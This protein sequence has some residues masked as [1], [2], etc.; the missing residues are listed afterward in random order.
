MKYIITESQLDLIAQRYALDTLKDMEFKKFKNKDFEFFPKGSH[1]ADLGI[2][3]DWVKKE[4][5]YD[6][7]VGFGL[8]KSVRDLFNLNDDETSVAF[9]NA[10]SDLGIKNINRVSTIDFT[11]VEKIMG[12]R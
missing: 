1:T 7:L 8:W 5:G 2:E 10:L 9:Q 12:L 4:N 3:A 6:V 11:E